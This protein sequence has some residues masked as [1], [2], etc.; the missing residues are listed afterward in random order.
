MACLGAAGIDVHVLELEG[1]EPAKSHETLFRIYDHL[2]A[3]KVRR[4]GTLAAFGGGVIGDVAGFAAA[5]WQ[6]GIR[7]VQIPSTLL[8]Q[9]DS[10]VGGKT[11]LNFREHKNLVGAFH[12]PSAVL[13]SPEWLNS[14]P[15][16]EFRAGL[17]E[18]I[19]CGAIR[20]EGLLGILEEENPARLGRSS[21]L[22]EIVARAL[23]VKTRIV[24]QDERERGLR[25]VL[26]FGHTVGHAI[27]SATGFRHYLH[28]EAVAIGTVAAARLSVLAAGL[29][30]EE[31]QRLE[32]LLRRYGLPTRTPAADLDA[33]LGFLAMDK[34]VEA[35]GPVWVL[36]ARLGAATV[37]AQV[38]SGAVREAV[39][40]ILE[41]SVAP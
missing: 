15:S 9:V 25:R 17:A 11:G 5:T 32:A 20:D 26:N 29:P 4:D 37:A 28:G 38:P 24:E 40:Y 6:R 34:K 22:D 19:K 39:S 1:G 41:E 16:R 27:E 23:A 21:R 33:I 30:E 12:Q 31:A 35:G 13:I 8:A 36:T 3:K 18:V 14:L 10:S 2:L 7:F